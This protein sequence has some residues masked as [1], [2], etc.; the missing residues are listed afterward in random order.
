MPVAPYFALVDGRRGVVVG[1]G[2]A[3]TWDRVHDLLDR[4]LADAG[5]EGGQVRR[6][7]LLFGKARTERV[8]R[9]LRQA[10]FVPGDERLYH[11]AATDASDEEQDPT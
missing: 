8:D 4:A 1:E 9:D 11:P 3:N 7:D 2:A 6:R 5:Y 10:G